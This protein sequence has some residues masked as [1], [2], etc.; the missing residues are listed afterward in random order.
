MAIRVETRTFV[1][2]HMTEPKGAGNWGFRFSFDGSEPT[3]ETPVIWVN[4][5]FT[6]AVAEA[7]RRVRRNGFQDGAL[8]VQP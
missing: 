2:S 5:T 7:K 6:S 3:D 1:R 8:F 4:D